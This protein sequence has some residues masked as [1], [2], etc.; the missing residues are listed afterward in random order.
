MF[1][2]KIIPE[3]ELC[4][5]RVLQVPICIQCS[6]CIFLVLGQMSRNPARRRTQASW[7]RRPF[8][9]PARH[10]LG[11]QVP[12]TANRIPIS[13]LAVRDLA[14]AVLKRF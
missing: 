10:L 4:N 14:S 12:S 11:R 8:A 3:C 5:L 7:P 13:L 6:E 9:L 1:E 2:A